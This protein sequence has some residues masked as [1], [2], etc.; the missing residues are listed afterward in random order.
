MIWNSETASTAGKKGY[1]NSRVAQFEK[2]ITKV[3]NYLK[4]PNFCEQCNEPLS[5]EKRNGKFCNRTCAAIYNGSKFPKRKK[6]DRTK[7]CLNCKTLT[8]NNK[9]CS[10]SCYSEFYKK[11]KKKKDF[12]LIPEGKQRNTKVL[13]KYLIEKFGEKC[14]IC[15]WSE[16]NIFTQKIPIEMHHKDGNGENNNEENLQLLCPNHHSLTSTYRNNL[17]RSTRKNRQLTKKQLERKKQVELEGKT[18]IKW[19]LELAKQKASTFKSKQ[20]F[21]RAFYGGYKFLIRYDKLWLETNFASI[22]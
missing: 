10:S 2:H 15:G 13:K 17:G 22:A 18:L 12:K 5:Y 9:F 11:Q 8:S 20:E 6:I 1:K 14:M 16:R 21:R 4:E 7:E 19:T 3:N